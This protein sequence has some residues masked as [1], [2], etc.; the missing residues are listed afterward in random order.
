[1][2][3]IAM[4]LLV[5][6]AIV[7]A[8]AS[9][10]Q[11]RH[12]AWGYVAAFAEAAMVGALADWFAVVALF[13]HPLGLP[14]P[15][16]AIIPS[17]K[18]RIGENLAAFICTN[19]LGTS[20]VLDKLREFRAADRLAAWLAD[21]HHA[22]QVSI[23]LGALLSHALR[24]LDDEPVRHFFRSTVLARLG[25]VDSTRLLGELLDVL[26][27]D[28][29]HQ[30]V[31]DAALR[32]LGRVLD[33]ETLKQEVADVV[34]AEVKYLRF[35]GLDTAAGRFATEKMVAGVVRLVSEMGED[36]AHPLRQRFDEF[37]R[38]F[39]ADLK[40][41]AAMREKGERLKAELLGHPQ[42]ATYLHGLW[43]QV[44]DWTRQDLARDDSTLR[45]RAAAATRALGQQL[46]DDVAMREWID[47]QLLA[48]AP[49]WIDRYRED[50]RRY[51]VNRVSS[52][53]ADEMTGE[54]ERN[55]G[56]DLQFI[57]INGTLVGGL[58]GLLIHAM[59]EFLRTGTLR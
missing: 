11:A 15:H 9:F 38:G 30:Q 34:A 54:L 48:G 29:R 25:R 37:M 14:I 56:R 21:P 51:I 16:T 33:D 18:D 3:W 32:Q 40:H 23:H 43:S 53:N 28:G 2:K 36:P 1:M 35:V 8:V 27:A 42:L 6:A 46:Q 58:A 31:L 45:A 4:A 17:N 59:T 39:I 22:Q 24:A 44:I 26:T 20:Q 47:A 55:I 41:D 50:I 12:A 10:Q 57:R 19:F 52:W 49:R 13:R 7:Y 5:G